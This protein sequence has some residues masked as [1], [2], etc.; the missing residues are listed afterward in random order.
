MWEGRNPP[1][2]SLTP[3]PLCRPPIVVSSEVCRLLGGSESDVVGWWSSEIT[4]LVVGGRE[5]RLP[6]SRASISAMTV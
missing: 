5:V 1:V 4:Y 6:H 2:Q 3:R